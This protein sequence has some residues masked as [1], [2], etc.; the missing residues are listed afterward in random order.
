MSDRCH[1]DVFEVLGSQLR[2]NCFVDRV[3]AE[4]RLVLSEAKAPQPSSEGTARSGLRNSNNVIGDGDQ[5]SHCPSA[6]VGI[7]QMH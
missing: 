6:R 3:L 2:Q 5:P 4:C 7:D 1:A